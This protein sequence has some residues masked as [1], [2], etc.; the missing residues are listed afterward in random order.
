[1]LGSLW[2]NFSYGL[3][4]NMLCPTLVL[5]QKVSLFP[6]LSDNFMFKSNAKFVECDFFLV[7][8]L[9]HVPVWRINVL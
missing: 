9:L 4:N 5:S 3:K 7:L 6:L 8:C 1:M 2:S